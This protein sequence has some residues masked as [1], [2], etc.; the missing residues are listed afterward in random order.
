MSYSV[1]WDGPSARDPHRGRK[2][3]VSTETELD[4]VLDQVAVESAAKGIAFAVQIN[5]AA[6]PGAV[7]IGVGDPGRS[8]VDWLMDKGHRLYGHE[9]GVAAGA[10]PV[11]YDVYGN[12]HE[13][14]PE[15]SRV[16]PAVAREAAREYV[17]TGQRPTC[18]SW[19]VPD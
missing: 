7:M 17:R 15:Q 5:R 2:A 4:A 8:F 11:A 1:S 3:T 9:P 13:H 19:G 10:D 6:S 14:P 12:F 16:T 18:V